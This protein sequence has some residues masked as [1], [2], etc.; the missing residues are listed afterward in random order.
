MEQN[1]RKS[2][3]VYFEPKDRIVTKITMKPYIG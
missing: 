1:T 3:N 2:A